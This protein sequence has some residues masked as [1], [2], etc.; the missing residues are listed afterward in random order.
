MTDSKFKNNVLLFAEVIVP[1]FKQKPELKEPFFKNFNQLLNQLEYQGG[2]KIRLLVSVI[3]LLSFVYNFKAFHKLTYQKRKLFIDKLFQF[4]V[5]KIV[6]GLTGLRS[7]VL[8]SYY[9]LED[10]VSKINTNP[11]K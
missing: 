7:L 9:G 10:V 1:D 6:A 2:S 8:I 11:D 5:G 4:P 3:E